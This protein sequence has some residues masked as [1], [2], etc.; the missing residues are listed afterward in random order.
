MSYASFP[1]TEIEKTEVI[2]NV[3]VPNY[4]DSKPIWGFLSLTFMLIS[5]ILIGN[6]DLMLISTCLGLIF[7]AIGI[8]KKQKGLAFFGSILSLLLLVFL[9]FH[10]R[11]HT[12]FA[13]HGFG[14]FWLPFASNYCIMTIFCTAMLDFMTFRQA[15]PSF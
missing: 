5:F 2:A 3:E 9:S 1:I 4:S 12:S 14:F 15:A 13:C 8:K 7:G 10:S 11:N 6:V